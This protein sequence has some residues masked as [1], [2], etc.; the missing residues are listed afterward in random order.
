MQEDSSISN[1]LTNASNPGVV[2]QGQRCIR[3]T[4]IKYTNLVFLVYTVKFQGIV[5]RYYGYYVLNTIAQPQGKIFW[6]LVNTSS[7]KNLV[8]YEPAAFFRCT[9]CFSGSFSGTEPYF[10]VTSR[11]LSTPLHSWLS[12]RSRFKSH[13]ENITMNQP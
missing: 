12:D 9:S 4:L 13:S 8:F 1:P 7:Y 11:R 10:S 6:F 5:Y 3:C 2:Y